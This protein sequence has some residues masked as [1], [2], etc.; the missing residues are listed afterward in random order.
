MTCQS[1][2]NDYVR[3]VSD[4]CDMSRHLMQMQDEYLSAV[5]DGSDPRAAEV[6]RRWRLYA[7]G[8]TRLLAEEGD[9]YESY[10]SAQ[11]HHTGTSR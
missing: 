7:D 6:Y 9:F 10:A 2:R 5:R 11:R 4:L 1:S 3:A 8:L